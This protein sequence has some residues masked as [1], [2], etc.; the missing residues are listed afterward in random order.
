VN[1]P[2]GWNR[3]SEKIRN[4]RGDVIGDSSIYVYVVKAR[5]GRYAYAQPE[6]LGV[7]NQRWAA[8]VH[9][10]HTNLIR[11]SLK[12]PEISDVIK[13]NPMRLKQWRGTGINKILPESPISSEH[14]IHLKP[15]EILK[16]A[17][18]VGKLKEMLCRSMISAVIHMEGA[19]Q[20][21]LA[22]C[23]LYSITANEELALRVINIINQDC[24]SVEDF[25]KVWKEASIRAKQLQ[26]VVSE[27]LTQLF[28]LDVLLNRGIG[29]LDWEQE[30]RNRIE[31]KTVE[32][33]KGKIYE[34]VVKQL[35]QAKREKRIEYKKQSWEEWWRVRWLNTPGGSVHPVSSRL[36]YK[37]R[38]LKK[39]IGLSKKLFLSSI[40]KWDINDILAIQPSIMAYPSEKYEWGK[41]RAIYG[42]DLEGFM[43]CDF[44]FPSFEQKLPKL[45]VTGSDASED[46]VKRLVK[47]NLEGLMPFCFD[48]EDFNS[49]HSIQSMREV[50]MAMMSVYKQDM[51][52]E[53]QEAAYWTLKSLEHIE[54]KANKTLNCKG[55]RVAA[56]LMSG[57]RLTT[58][59]NSLLNYA[60]LDVCGALNNAVVTMHS[61]DDVLSAIINLRQVYKFTEK[62]KKIGIRAQER[63]CFASSISEFLRVDHKADKGTSS[64]YLSRACSTYV[65]S[66][67]ESR[68]ALSLLMWLESIKVR[69]TEM[70]NR[71]ATPIVVKYLDEMQGRRACKIYD[72][73]ISVIGLYRNLHP[74]EGGRNDRATLKGYQIEVEPATLNQAKLADEA[75]PGIR[76]YAMMLAAKFKV[77]IGHTFS[78]IKRVT[79]NAIVRERRRVNVSRYLVTTTLQRKALRYGAFKKDL[80]K[81][82]V[83]MYK[84]ISNKLALLSLEEIPGPISAIIQNSKNPLRDLI[85]LS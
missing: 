76:D 41:R 83:P 16:V 46:K 56:T 65:H 7:T 3:Y 25:A 81:T 71:G 9:A 21:T 18:E 2:T 49:Q 68:E 63:K 74:M 39:E 30:I 64:Q 82:Q 15:L 47:N 61:G 44:A 66:R 51:S 11:R 77:E 59:M 34:S 5:G 85:H 26:H 20:H 67:P 27:D 24:K 55:G 45:I 53:Q 73:D 8:T 10:M 33:E 70:L 52:A 42:T 72:T 48:Y 62:T 75:E 32:V 12:L 80:R 40:D 37:Y 54:V 38:E 17:I 13:P 29:K 69:S 22:T 4:K 84:G 36:E 28:E 23:M 19:T 57:W 60:Y 43:M 79:I 1:L 31:L 50:I 6:A 78:A 14:H 35:L 58:V